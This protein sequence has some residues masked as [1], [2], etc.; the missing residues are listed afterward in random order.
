MVFII[1]YLL[2]QYPQNVFVLISGKPNTDK[3]HPDYIPSVFNHV[4]STPQQKQKKLKRYSSA[5][6]RKLTDNMSPV[7][8]KRKRTIMSNIENQPDEVFYTA[9]PLVE[10]QPSGYQKEMEETER[11]QFHSEMDSLREERDNLKTNISNMSE[12]MHASSLNYNFV[13]NN[14]ERCK[15]YTGVQWIR[16]LSIFNV[17]S[18]FVKPTP[19]SRNKFPHED[20]LFITLV[21]LRHDIPF[22]FLANMKGVS[23]ATFK[24]KVSDQMA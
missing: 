12:T 13:K 22:E 3:T 20:Q 10:A 4:P 15:F 7:P 18:M 16:F 2:K 8:E 19:I 11:E 24:I 21:K 6:K 9:T 14:D 17:L 1:F 23:V 5:V